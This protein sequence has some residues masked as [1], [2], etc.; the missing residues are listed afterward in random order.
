MASVSVNDLIKFGKEK[1]VEPL[2]FSQ[3][4]HYGAIRGSEQLRRNI[5]G[6]YGGKA[7]ALVQPD[8]ILVTPGA[9]MANFLLFYTLIGPGD[10]VI[11]VHPTYS[12]LY[13]VP[14]S[15]GAVVD[16]WRLRE[17]NN[18]IPD[19]AELEALLKPNTKLIV[20]K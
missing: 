13:A 16:L 1:N 8:N 18:F 4:L 9:I 14:R 6:L 3:T 11:C 20:I 17:E 2:S 15:L 5:A 12:Q 7:A 10:H 19:V